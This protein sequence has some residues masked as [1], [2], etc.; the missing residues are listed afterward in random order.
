MPSAHSAFLASPGQITDEARRAKAGCSARELRLGKS[1]KDRE[2]GTPHR[3]Q[4]S[5]DHAPRSQKKSNHSLAIVASKLTQPLNELSLFLMPRANRE[6]RRG[7]AT[8]DIIL[9][10]LLHSQRLDGD[11]ACKQRLFVRSWY[12]VIN[13]T[14]LRSIEHLVH[15]LPDGGGAATAPRSAAEAAID[16]GRGAAR[17][18]AGDSSHLVVAQYVAGADNHRASVGRSGPRPPPCAKD[19]LDRKSPADR[20][21][22]GTW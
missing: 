18:R 21:Q 14:D 19:P 16:I 2:K 22:P 5:C 11:A 4:A 17:R 12:G 15:Y 1:R 20:D 3:R 7:E 13:W 9:V 8:I 6:S 10:P